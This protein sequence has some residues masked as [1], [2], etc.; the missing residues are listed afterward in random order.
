MDARVAVVTSPNQL[1]VETRRVPDP[2]TGEALIRVHECGI[3][4]SDL[5]LYGGKH[6][7]VKPPMI[8]GHE[9]YGSVEALGPGGDGPEPG[10]VVAVFAPVGCGRCFNCRRGRPHLCPDMEF[11]GGQRQ[12]GLSELVTVPAANLVPMDPGV[13]PDRRVLVE[14]LAVGVHAVARA[15]VAPEERVLV[16]GAGP[17]GLFTALALR[18]RGVEQIVLTDL[19]DDRL[20]LA[21]RL[22]AGETVNTRDVSLDDYVRDA[23][24]PD[25]VDVAFD[26]VGL[27]A[28]TADALRLTSKGGRVILVGLMP[29]DLTVDGVALQR[30]ERALVGVQQ[31][32]REDYGT[33]M[34]ILASGALPAAEELIR[35]YRLEDVVT[36]FRDLQE[37]RTDV[38][39]Y[40]VAP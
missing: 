30:G 1:N 5:K 35:S 26:C 32:V 33:A 18:S 34:E 14:P 8:L 29:A 3:C 36:A 28:T 4:G 24:R 16:I 12:G 25:G 39:K 37:G 15:E 22:G 27:E 9:F 20:A 17:I 21:R 11:I 19:S 10:T 23:V 40:A 6:P 31:Y 38:L 7:V 13:P 2:A